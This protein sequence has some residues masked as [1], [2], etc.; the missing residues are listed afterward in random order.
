MTSVDFWC[1]LMPCGALQW[2]FVWLSMPFDDFWYHL[3][4]LMT[5]DDIRCLF[6]HLM[7]LDNSLRLLMPCDDFL[8]TANTFLH[9]FLVTIDELRWLCDIFF[10]HPNQPWWH[11]MPFNDCRTYL[12]ACTADTWWWHLMTCDPTRWLWHD[13]WC[14]WWLLMPSGDLCMTFW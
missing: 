6:I 2:P 11:L 14:L 8:M 7:P 13:F 1:F 12:M 9:N 5:F 3:I 10:S 4:Q